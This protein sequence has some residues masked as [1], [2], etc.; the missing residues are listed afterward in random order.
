MAYGSCINF[1]FFLKP[2]LAV[3]RCLRCLEIII[4]DKNKAILCA[5]AVPC[6]ASDLDSELG[7]WL[8]QTAVKERLMKFNPSKSQIEMKRT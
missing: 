2:S 5:V 8:S 6:Y 7:L 3:K 4:P 1:Y